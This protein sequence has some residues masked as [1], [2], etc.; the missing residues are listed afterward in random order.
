MM[1][2]DSLSH[3]HYCD[4]YLFVFIYQKNSH[5]T[6]ALRSLPVSRTT[7]TFSRAPVKDTVTHFAA[8][9]A[10]HVRRRA[11]WDCR[12]LPVEYEI[13]ETQ[14]YAPRSGIRNGH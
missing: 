14:H 9:R 13:G 4:Y 12:G 1:I 5:F 7:V 2:I 6:M 3:I 8:E 11:G 10:K